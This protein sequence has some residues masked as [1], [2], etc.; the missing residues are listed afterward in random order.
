MN[1][2]N[3]DILLKSQSV[4]MR[5]T[6]DV[7]VSIAT[8]KLPGDNQPIAVQEIVWLEGDSNYTR[9]HFQNRKVQLITR[10]LKWFDD[11]LPDFL[12]IHRSI[13]V[14]PVFVRH[15]IRRADNTVILQLK[16]GS[17]LAVSRRRIRQTNLDLTAFRQR[18][19]E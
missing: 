10:T 8:I 19:Q 5:S 13:L 18:E 2:S 3:A 14:N 9:V 6:D 11:E 16:D 7:C 4:S 15:L 17:K 12:R 1:R